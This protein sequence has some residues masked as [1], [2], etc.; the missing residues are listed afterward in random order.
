MAGQGLEDVRR[1]LRGR[2]YVLHR[3]SHGGRRERRGSHVG[4]DPC[5]DSLE[6][7]GSH[8]GLAQRLR[9]GACGGGGVLGGSGGALKAL[10]RAL[11]R[12]VNVAP[13]PLGLTQLVLIGLIEIVKRLE[14]VRVNVDVNDRLG[15]RFSLSGDKVALPPGVGV[16]VLGEPVLP[17]AGR[18]ARGGG[19][20]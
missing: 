6:R 20:V 16:G 3:L 17:D 13:E 8:P 15:H 9:R 5:Q 11:G 2:L 10:G 4:G 7:P 19:E 18:E 14:V 1:A 12:L